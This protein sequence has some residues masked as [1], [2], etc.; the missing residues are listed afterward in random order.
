[1]KFDAPRTA[2]KDLRRAHFTGQPI[3][4]H[5]YSVAGV[6][7]EQLVATHMGVAHGNREVVLPTSV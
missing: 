4:D 7:D 5:R 3:D 2:T 6:I 1:V